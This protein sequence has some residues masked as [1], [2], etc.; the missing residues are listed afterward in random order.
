MKRQYRQGDV[1]I[2]DATLPEGLNRRNDLVVAYGEATGHAHRF[3]DESAVALYDAPDGDMFADIR[4]KT[5]LVHDEHDSITLA[6]GTYRIRR[7]R[8]YT[9]GA[10]RRV[11]D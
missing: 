5:A 7:Q 6:P 3:T 9:P 2:V 1:L 4:E 8:E 10:I 11:E